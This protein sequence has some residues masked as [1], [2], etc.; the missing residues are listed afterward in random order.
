MVRHESETQNEFTGLLGAINKD[1]LSKSEFTEGI[2]PSL[3]ALS[4]RAASY[5]SIPAEQ[6]TVDQNQLI[7]REILE[8]GFPGVLYSEDVNRPY[9][10]PIRAVYCFV[11]SL[12]TW[13]LIF[14]CIGFSQHH[15]DRE[16]R[17]WRY[18]SDS[19]YW[20]YLAH[21]PIQFQILIWLGD[22]PWHWM[23]KFGVY[24]VGTTAVLLP[25]YHFLVR[26]TW[27]GWFLNGRMASVWKRPASVAETDPEL[28]TD[29]TSESDKEAHGPRLAPMPMFLRSSKSRSSSEN[30]D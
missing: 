30:R 24:V 16:S 25:S 1:I 5:A 6:R 8:A 12:I 10:Y 14:G 9:Y 13:L 7:N 15:F 21:L 26:P 11:Y 27:I 23:V 19:S 20:F 2:D 22:A 4:S 17:F 28:E 3:Y 29:D 18:F